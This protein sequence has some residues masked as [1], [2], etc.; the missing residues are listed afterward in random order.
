ME[1][2]RRKLER[3]KGR[4]E[5]GVGKWRG[6]GEG[7]RVGGRG[8]GGWEKG[9]GR[10]E[11]ERACA[12]AVRVVTLHTTTGLNSAVRCF[13]SNTSYFKYVTVDLRPHP[14]WRHFISDVSFSC[15]GK[16][17]IPGRTA[18]DQVELGLSCSASQRSVMAAHRSF[19]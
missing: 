13:T 8:R 16:C 15:C 18:P 7:K 10:G 17:P 6:M 14:R 11:V 4:V 12:C 5:G 3:I 2:D 19:N 9:K 1:V